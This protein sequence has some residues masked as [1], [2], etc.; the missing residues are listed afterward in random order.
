MFDHY[1]R[2]LK[3]RL[4][5]PVVHAIGPGV[6][7][8]A[9]SLLALLSGLA[10]AGAA[11]AGLYPLALLLWL[12]NRFLDGL[13]GAVARAHAQQSPFGAYLDI[14]LDFVVYAAIPAALALAAPTSAV[15]DACIL[16]L[17]SFF[18]NAASWMYLAALLEQRQAGAAARGELTTVTMPPGLI[19]GTETVAFYT[20]FLLLPGRLTILFTVMAGLVLLTVMLRLW[21]AYLHLRR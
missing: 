13:D 9:I 1:L 15:A 19:A 14:V 10:C 4:L 8:N 6:H 16:L 12:L 20:L 5:T 21:W 17:A 3:D 2:A 18:I 7:P 11:G